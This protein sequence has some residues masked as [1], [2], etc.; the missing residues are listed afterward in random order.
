MFIIFGIVL[1]LLGFVGIIGFEIDV[2]LSVIPIWLAKKTADYQCFGE[3]KL[4]ALFT[5]LV[6]IAGAAVMLFDAFSPDVYYGFWPIIIP[7]LFDFLVMLVEC[8][9]IKK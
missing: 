6:G 4:R 7:V 9:L 8:F 1:V 2:F 5:Y 3:W